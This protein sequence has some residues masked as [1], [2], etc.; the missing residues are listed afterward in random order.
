MIDEQNIGK[1]K[2]MNMT[3]GKNIDVSRSQKNYWKVY[4]AMPGIHILPQ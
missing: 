3:G 2:D 1:G 4:F